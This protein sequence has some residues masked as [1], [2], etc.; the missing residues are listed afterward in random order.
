MRALISVY[1]KTGLEDFAKGS[2]SSAGSS[3]RA[4]VRA[5]ALRELGLDV[6]SVE[7]LTEF[8]RCSAAA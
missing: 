1:D 4:A 8:P 3:S 6:T 2:P 5:D 7:D